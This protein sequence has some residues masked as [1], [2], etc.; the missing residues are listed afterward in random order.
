LPSQLGQTQ[1]VL[2]VVIMVTQ[3][4]GG[5]VSGSDAQNPTA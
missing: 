1:V 4:G 5:T 3:G 2:K